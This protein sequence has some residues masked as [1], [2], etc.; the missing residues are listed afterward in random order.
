MY[1]FIESCL[2]GD[3]LPE[4]IDDYIDQWHEGDSEESLYDFLGMRRDEYAAWVEQPDVLPF[5]IT[6]HKKK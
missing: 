4:D 6:A 1:N 3:S 2:R 5:I